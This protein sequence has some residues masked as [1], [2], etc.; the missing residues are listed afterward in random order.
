MWEVKGKKEKK[1]E[2]EKRKNK[3]VEKL[4][5]NSTQGKKTSIKKT[6]KTFQHD[7]RIR[8]FRN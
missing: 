7:Y 5:K 2:R 1:G 8:G 3:L 6:P 4:K